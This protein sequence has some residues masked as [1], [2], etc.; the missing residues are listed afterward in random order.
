MIEAPR[1][2]Y[3]Y[4]K[5]SMIKGCF[6]LPR[7]N[8]LKRLYNENQHSVQ[9]IQT[10][11]NLQKT[12]EMIPIHFKIKNSSPFL[13]RFY[14]LLYLSSCC[15][16][17]QPLRG[18][19]WS[20]KGWD[21]RHSNQQTDLSFQS[22]FTLYPRKVNGCEWWNMLSEF[23]MDGWMSGYTQRV[24]EKGEGDKVIRWWWWWGEVQVWR[25]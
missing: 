15:L 18:E 9:M 12:N 22:F 10:T 8:H 25:N 2:G 11:K 16:L 5:T 23:W 13:I 20:T 19:Q 6:N 21:G 7:F 3:K 14:Y 4:P 24:K 17:L 1:S